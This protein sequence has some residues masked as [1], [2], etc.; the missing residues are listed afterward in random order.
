MN[1]KTN[2]QNPFTLTIQK[3]HG[4]QPAG[5]CGL[6]LSGDHQNVFPVQGDFKQ[7]I[8]LVNTN[9]LTP[10]NAPKSSAASIM[11]WELHPES[12]LKW[13]TIK[14]YDPQQTHIYS[15]S[16]SARAYTALIL[17]FDGKGSSLLDVDPETAHQLLIEAGLSHW[18]Y[19][20]ASHGK[21]PGWNRFRVVIPLKKAL[22]FPSIRDRKRNLITHFEA[23]ITGAGRVSTLDPAC[24][25][26]CQGFLAPHDG[27]QQWEHHEDDGAKPFDLLSVDKDPKIVSPSTSL[28]WSQDANEYYTRQRGAIVARTVI[29]AG[30]RS[31]QLFVL[32]RKLVK[33]HATADQITTTLEGVIRSQIRGKIKQQEHISEIPDKITNAVAQVSKAGNYAPVP[34]MIYRRNW[35]ALEDVQPEIMKALNDNRDLLLNATPGSGK[36]RYTRDWAVEQ[37]AKG[38]I[39]GWFV[40]TKDNA[41]ETGAAFRAA[42]VDDVR[43]IR[44]RTTETCPA[45]AEFSSRQQIDDGTGTG[46]SST[47]YCKEECSFGK[48]SSTGLSRCPYVNQTLN[49]EPGTV[50]VYNHSHLVANSNGCRDKGIAALDVAIVDEDILN[51]FFNRDCKAAYTVAD[52]CKMVPCGVGLWKGLAESKPFT[53]SDLAIDL[54]CNYKREAEHVAKQLKYTRIPMLKHLR[55][56]IETG[57]TSQQIWTDTTPAGEV[58]IRFIELPRFAPSMKRQT[59]LIMLDGSGDLDVAK[60]VT[61]RNQMIERRVDVDINPEAVDVIQITDGLSFSKT[62]LNDDDGKRQ[63]SINAWCRE[64]GFYNLTR[65]DAADEGDL[66]LGNQRG[67]NSIEDVRALALTSVYNIPENELCELVRALFPRSMEPI[68]LTRERVLEVGRG[69]Y[70]NRP[71]YADPRVRR[72]RDYISRGELVQA[73][74]RTRA[75]RRDVDHPLTIVL[76]VPEVL[77]ITVTRTTPLKDLNDLLDGRDL[78]WEAYERERTAKKAAGGMTEPVA[79]TSAVIIEGV[80]AVAKQPHQSKSLNSHNQEKANAAFVEFTEAVK[81]AIVDNGGSLQWKSGVIRKAAPSI[82]R[83]KWEIHS[84]KVDELLAQGLEVVAVETNRKGRTQT[85]VRVAV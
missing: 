32:A 19:T 29:E 45:F 6:V 48:V 71:R 43:V 26:E 31:R 76:F 20:T 79:D 28:K 82:T 68:S 72:V 53:P 46:T 9:W 23:M 51:R 41:A 66:Y 80:Q 50:L 24:L 14:G 37:A 63:K 56:L 73:L 49:I 83:R 58:F 77:D 55:E 65:K 57:T 30:K 3:G 7:A 17:D 74:H 21:L 81:T 85:I 34:D 62:W 1:E 33:L 10:S 38:N 54:H 2:N 16:K 35:T 67:S 39:I 15:R 47:L 40:S 12:K 11:P 13:R 64:R 25:S 4:N 27:S 44:A 69:F 61:A 59:R 78:E 84:T 75:I 52:L 70:S 8:K 36:S 18:I 5:I 42:G 60:A 22:G